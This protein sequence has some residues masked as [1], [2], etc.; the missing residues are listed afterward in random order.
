MAEEMRITDHQ[1]YWVFVNFGSICN[2]CFE[3]QIPAGK[4]NAVR[5]VSLP[6]RF[7]EVIIL[8]RKKE[9]KRII[10]E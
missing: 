5:D 4:C 10:S 8:F 6:L 9:F 3:N 7:E 1:D 2:R